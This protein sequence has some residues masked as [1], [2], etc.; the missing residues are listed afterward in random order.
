M[1]SLIARENL[2]EVAGAVDLA[3]V[4]AAGGAVSEETGNG[5]RVV[6]SVVQWSYAA[7]ATLP[8]GVGDDG[9]VWLAITGKVLRGTAG[10]GVLSRDES[11]F[12]VRTSVG[13]SS[14]FHDTLLV[15]QHPEEA[16]KLIIENDTAGD[17][18]AEVLVSKITLFARA[19]SDLLGRLEFAEVP[20]LLKEADILAS[21]AATS[22]EQHDSAHIVTPPGQW[23]PH[24]YLRQSASGYSRIRNSVQRRTQILRPRFCGP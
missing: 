2:K 22:M 15:V 1:E 21:S 6:T 10:F 7:A 17:Q 20:G 5:L 4:S 12:L 9:T 19:G 18:K 8:F 23:S 3:D 13:P 11:R 24:P 16:S 14:D